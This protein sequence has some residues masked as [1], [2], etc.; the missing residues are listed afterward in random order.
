MISEK[1]VKKFCS[2]DISEIENYNEAINSN[3]LYDCHHRLETH[4]PNGERLFENYSVDFLKSIGMYYKRPSNELIFLTH[5][6]HASLHSKNNKV[7]LG[8]KWSEETRKRMGDG[9]RGRKASEETKIRQSIAISKYKHPVRCLELNLIF[10]SVGEAS[11]YFDVCRSNIRQSI[12]HNCRC[13][14]CHWEYIEV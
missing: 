10:D 13:C 12:N 9:H 4:F 6:N 5:K 11:K 7:N 2:G 8:R 3:E 1:M 14:G